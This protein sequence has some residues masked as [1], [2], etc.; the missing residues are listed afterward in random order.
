MPSDNA[1]KAYYEKNKPR[2]LAELKARRDAIRADPMA[3]YAWHRYQRDRMLKQRYGVSHADYEAMLRAQGGCCAICGVDQQQRRK[4]YFD[5]D[6][7]HHT[8]KVR[9]LLCGRCNKRLVALEDAEWRERA[10]SYLLTH[11]HYC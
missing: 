10:E 6:H 1:K 3:R 11:D 8:G 2:I 9:G 7:N 5:V 4:R